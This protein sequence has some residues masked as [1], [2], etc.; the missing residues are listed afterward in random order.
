MECN[1]ATTNKAQTHLA[2]FWKLVPYA[3][4]KVLGTTLYEIKCELVS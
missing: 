1:T 3:L 2:A 4:Q